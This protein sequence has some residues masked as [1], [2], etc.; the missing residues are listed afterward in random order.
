MFSQRDFL[1]LHL[2]PVSSLAEGIKGAF[3]IYFKIVLNEDILT[4]NQALRNNSGQNVQTLR[5]IVFSRF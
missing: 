1:C 2:L 4:F 5:N 3:G